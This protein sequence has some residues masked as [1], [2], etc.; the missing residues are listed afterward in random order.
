MFDHPPK[1]EEKVHIIPYRLV[2]A[3]DG[4][5]VG[6]EF[7]NPVTFHNME[8]IQRNQTTEI[9][10]ER[11]AYELAVPFEQNQVFIIDDRYYYMLQVPYDGSFWNFKE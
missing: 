10:K 6:I 3:H 7:V 11:I 2:P 8:D 4:C 5:L 9:F 1:V